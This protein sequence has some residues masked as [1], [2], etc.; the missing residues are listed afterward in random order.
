M[1]SGLGPLLLREALPS[2]VMPAASTPRSDHVSPGGNGGE[3][4]GWLALTCED[5]REEAEGG[6]ELSSHRPPRLG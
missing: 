6:R 3:G 5:T 2:P 1:S 4:S